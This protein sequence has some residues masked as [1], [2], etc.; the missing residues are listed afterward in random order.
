MIKFSL[1]CGEGHEFEGWFQSGAAYEAQS[2]ASQV[3]CPHCG[4]HAVDKAIMAPAVAKRVAA[5][6]A[7]T[8]AS[9]IPPEEIRRMVRKVR[10]EIQDKAEYVGGRFA[11]EARKIHFNESPSRGIYGGASSDEVKSLAEDGVP[12]LPIP[13][14]PDDMN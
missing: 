14:V 2:A 9:K 13:R 12:F 4:S 10:D 7:H 5:E 11:E 8:Y 3:A 1:V 6:P